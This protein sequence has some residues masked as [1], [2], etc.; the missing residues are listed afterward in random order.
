MGFLSFIGSSEAESRAEP[1]NAR[2]VTD[3]SGLMGWVTDQDIGRELTPEGALALSAVYGSVRILA[4]TLATT[5]I[6]SF[7]RSGKRRLPHDRPF[8]LDQPNPE[9]RKIEFI[10]SVMT[11]LLLEGNAYIL[12]TRALG[13][14]IALDVIPA[15]AVEPKYVRT[16]RGRKLVFELS[17]TDEDGR[18]QV[19]GALE[20]T[21]VLH[22]KGVTL[23]GSNKGVSPLKAARMTFSLGLAAQEY[24]A[25]FFER[26]AVPGAVI[27]VP[28][29]MTPAGLRAARQ[30]WR[31]IHGGRGNRHGL[32]IL[33]EDSK[34]QKITV[35]PDEAQ[36]LQTR[37]FQIPDVA[38]IFGVPPHLLA[39][40]S[41]STSW[42]S[43]LAEQNTAFVQF[44][45]R[46]WAE[47]LEEALTTLFPEAD[48]KA[49]AFVR[50]NLDGL[51]RGAL[52]ERLEAYRVGIANSVYTPDEVR[53]WE[54]LPPDPSGLG[55]YLR[56]QTSLAI[57]TP[58]GP[59]VLSGSA[60]PSPQETD[61]DDDSEA[62]QGTAS[63][64][65]DDDEASDENGGE[66]EGE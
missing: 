18:I 10:V 38:R 41:G 58:D 30:T 2:E 11:S 40:A 31:Q 52:K 60:A 65:Q 24:G 63:G 7:R 25:E 16:A 62:T 59:L 23:A 32:A 26:G 45:I 64:E 47:R 50:F 20:S 66:T 51:L 4:D 15:S 27:T 43:G 1:I 6:D 29:T 39:D 17:V 36:F 9:T 48:R 34:F 49:G 61:A 44:A 33:T 53:A 28:G 56:A 54:D 46:A 5:P 3:T 8:W 13:K 22:I 19:V 35:T 57:L 12:I 37:A 55:A 21:E 14:I 42:G